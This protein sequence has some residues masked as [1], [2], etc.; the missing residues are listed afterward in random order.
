MSVHHIEAGMTLDL[1]L[2]V[3]EKACY[4]QATEQGLAAQLAQERG[5]RAAERAQQQVSVS[6]L[7]ELIF[8]HEQST[9]NH[10]LRK[11]ISQ[12]W[13]SRSNPLVQ[14]QGLPT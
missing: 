9:S 7:R 8:E 11:M 3:P 5:N 13:P 2:P 1:Q 12:D 4:A 6:L 14:A 10:C